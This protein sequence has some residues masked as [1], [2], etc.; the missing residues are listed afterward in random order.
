MVARIVATIRII[1]SLS[2][3]EEKSDNPVHMKTKNLSLVLIPVLAYFSASP[4]SQAVSP[5]PDGGYPGGNTAEG[6][7]ALLSLTAGTYNTAVGLSSLQSNLTGDFN[8]AIGAGTLFANT[9][10]AN[11][12][13]GV[14]AL[15]NNT[16]GANNTAN[17]VFALFDNTT[18][19][20]NT[21][22]GYQASLA[23]PQQTAILPPV[24]KHSLTTP[25]AAPTRRTALQRSLATPPAAAMWPWVFKHFTTT[26]SAARIQPSAVQRSRATPAAA[27]R[28][29]AMAHSLKT[30][31]ATP[32]QLWAF[33]PARA[34]RRA[35]TLFVPAAMARTSTTAALSAIF[36]GSQRQLT[37]RFQW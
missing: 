23:T 1:L 2:Q 20:N 32:T 16:T 29:S 27:T 37:T 17:G 30:Q 4:S 5:P 22:I 21:A 9:A 6:Q 11:T 3:E 14:G 33:Q 26:P 18:G 36:M 25:L 7:N 13:T 10:D 24:F 28:L 19:G 34:L 8:T 15:L 12:A 31:P 35:L